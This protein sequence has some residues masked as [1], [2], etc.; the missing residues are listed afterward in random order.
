MA[1]SAPGLRTHLQ[2]ALSDTSSS[3][4]LPWTP[5]GAMSRGGPEGAWALPTGWTM[6]QGSGDSVASKDLGC[7]S[8]D[9]PASTQPG[10]LAGGQQLE[11][12]SIFLWNHLE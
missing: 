3:V 2:P 6:T 7:L 1:L 5:L 10:P 4:T 11:V 8:G 12:A 9:T